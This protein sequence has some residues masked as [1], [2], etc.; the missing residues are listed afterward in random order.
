MEKAMRDSGIEW[1]GAIPDNWTIGQIGQLYTER[2]EKVS[3]VDY[4]PLS[5]TMKGILP[6][7]STAAK[8]DAHDDRK[9]VKKGDFAINSRSDRRGSCG[10]SPYD[11]SVSL[12]NTILTPR[13][14]MHPVYYN[15]LFHSTMFSD[16]FYKWGHGIVDD[17]WTTGWQDMKRIT[18]PIPPYSEQERIASFLD[19]ECERIDELIEQTR[20]SIEE[21]KKLKQSVITQAVTK[22]IR[23]DRPMKD[24][25][26]EWI[27]EIP[28][29]WDIIRLKS[30]FN[31]GKGLPITKENL[32][33][34]GIPVI[35]YGQIH[36]K[37]TTGVEIQPH[38]LRFVSE[39]YLTSNPQ[40]LVHKGDFI[41]ADTSEDLDG[42]GN[43]VYVDY[44]TVLFA[45][46]HTIVFFSKEQTNNKYLAYLFRTD[47]W[48][49]QLRS[50]V[51]GIKVFSVSRKILGDTTCTRPAQDEAETIVAYLDEKCA[52]ID[53][54]IEKKMQ[55]ITELETYKKSLIYEYVTGKKEA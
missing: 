39:E 45:G 11:G 42:C 52:E 27:G 46:Y 19:T 14:E 31:F 22:G 51:S 23:G 18:V 30:A 17:L 34:T 35:S 15:W 28:E 55:L 4:Q 26:V 13:G 2:R 25:G 21:Y 24:S 12:I 1:I 44:E 41:F 16:E 3:D 49:S 53:K 48:R 43:A 9:L 8:T 5:V 54:L 20:A 37:N 33:E 7:L 40:S 29:E 50:K 32:I 47:A 10:I 36:A 38:L 6:Q